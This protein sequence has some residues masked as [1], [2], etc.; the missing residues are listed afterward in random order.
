MTTPGTAPHHGVS[1]LTDRSVTGPCWASREGPLA[2]K[3]DEA[4][5]GEEGGE[6]SQESLGVRGA[7]PSLCYLAG[8]GSHS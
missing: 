5:P 2:R 7:P 3:G 1:S 4:H 6:A 8:R